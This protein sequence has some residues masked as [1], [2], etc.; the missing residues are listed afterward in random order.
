MQ[1]KLV[2]L[3]FIFG[4]VIAALILLNSA[5]KGNLVLSE[6][7]GASAFYVDGKLHKNGD[8]LKGIRTGGH[9]IQIVGPFLINGAENVEVGAFRTTKYT[10]AAQT[11]TPQQ[12]ADS[13]LKIKGLEGVISVKAKVTSDKLWLLSYVNPTEGGDGDIYVYHFV[14]NQ[15]Q[16]ESAGT[17]FDLDGFSDSSLPKEVSD[18]LQGRSQ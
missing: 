16:E 3:I 2:F 15:W 4:L 10:P 13:L 12:L 11:V 17:N 6:T 14:D 5:G 1:K 18:I 8:T 7:V 9:I